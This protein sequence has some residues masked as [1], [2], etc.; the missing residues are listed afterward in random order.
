MA[1]TSARIT[2][3]TPLVL[4]D[5]IAIAALS[6]VAPGRVVGTTGY[7]PGGLAPF[8]QVYSALTSHSDEQ[9]QQLGPIIL[10]LFDPPADHPELVGLAL[11]QAAYVLTRLRPVD[12]PAIHQVTEH[13]IKLVTALTDVE[14]LPKHPVRIVQKLHEV[15][16]SDPVFALHTYSSCVSYRG[17]T[18]LVSRTPTDA[19]QRLALPYLRATRE[20]Q[21]LQAGHVAE[22]PSVYLFTLA[23]RHVVQS[24]LQVDPAG[25]EDAILSPSELDRVRE[26][27]ER[28]HGFPPAQLWLWHVRTYI[29]LFLDGVVENWTRYR[30]G[31]STR[32]GRPGLRR[33]RPRLGDP[34]LPPWGWR[35]GTGTPE[36]S[37]TVLV[38]GPAEPR[39]PRVEVEHGESPD[40]IA[41]EITEAPRG[42]V[43]PATAWLVG[44][45]QYQH[46]SRDR[47]LDPYA[48]GT[49]QLW[50]HVTLY[51]ADRRA[52][53][54]P[55]LLRTGVRVFSRLAIHTGIA[56]ET[57]CD[58]ELRAVP[59]TDDSP[60]S[61]GAGRCA[62]YYDE[63]AG[64]LWRWLPPRWTGYRDPESLPSDPYCR[65]TLR[66]WALHLPAFLQAEIAAYLRERRR[67]LSQAGQPMPAQV[68]L[69][70]VVP[71]T[72][73]T[74][75]E[76]AAVLK[77]G[78]VTEP[79]RLLNRLPASFM[80]LYVTR[81]GLAPPAATYVRGTVHALSATQMYYSHF[82]IAALSAA[83]GKAAEAA[84]ADMLAAAGFPT[85]ALKGPA[86]D[87]LFSRA[88]LESGVGSRV[89]PRPEGV[90]RLLTS[91]ARE[92]ALPPGQLGPDPI[93]YL[94]RFMATSYVVL[95]LGTGG[96]ASQDTQFA[97]MLE[98]V[99]PLRIRNADK[100]SPRFPEARTQGWN[101]L[102]TGQCAELALARRVA[103]RVHPGTQRALYALGY[104]L[105]FLLRSDGT[106]VRA[107]AGN[108][109]HVFARW[110]AFPEGFPLP[111]NFG[112]HTWQT[113]LTAQGV[114]WDAIDYVLGHQRVGRELLSRFSVTDV[115]AVEA[116]I[117]S[118]MLPIL[119]DAYGLAVVPFPRGFRP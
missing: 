111:L 86:S 24:L 11:P 15:K 59:C 115:A 19:Y 117:H 22:Y 55:R 43:D 74:V 28:R 89:T 14:P 113:E 103:E 26:N 54:I 46:V 48:A 37:G 92:L 33:D 10:E 68:F 23:C 73:L 13:L 31:A 25:L 118:V 6:L 109:L 38:L 35:Q 90:K 7:R 67:A 101:S 16:A 45:Q 1:S 47:I 62:V 42:L 79:M 56:P 107:T 20:L 112:R 44:Q 83:Y 97:V 70:M 30:R 119:T 39:A 27:L 72:P 18:R 50:E 69:A 17:K 116:H 84:H 100:H 87:D 108:V 58:L 82:E 51:R 99:H 3:T 76:A 77:A 105:L 95:H 63:A 94:N 61:Q 2:N 104:P 36:G 106:P 102:L 5:P 93:E 40:E 8:A 41:R 12:G 52:R 49:V 114:N 60:E 32:S 96:R 75:A 9:V 88:L 65:P 34:S 85:P 80:P 4:T 64:A 66:W 81:H 71:V 57:L 91:A 53:R 98:A 21:R 78:G 110:P 29:H